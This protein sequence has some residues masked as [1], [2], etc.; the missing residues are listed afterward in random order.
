MIFF[1]QTI[2]CASAVITL[3]VPGGH[4]AGPFFMALAGLFY[5]QQALQRTPLTD[6][7]IQASWIWLLAGF[8]SL[9]IIGIG[10]SLWHPTH[11]GHYEMYVP[12]VLFPAMAWLIRADRCRV[13]PWLICLSAGALLAFFYAS[14]QVFELNIARAYGATNHPIPFGNT[15]IVLSAVALVAGAIFPFEGPHAQW[16]RF[17]V[18]IAGAAG[19]GASLLSGSRGGWLS[20]FIVGFTVAYLATRHWPAWR[21]HLCAA[22]VIASLLLAGFLAPSHL[23]KDRLVTGF[24]GG[25]QWL[26]TG[27]VSDGSVGMRMEIWRLSFK[28][29]AEK[30]WFG[31]GSIGA[32]TRWEELRKEPTASP[33]LSQLYEPDTK[34]V[35][36]DNE[37]LGTL[38]G[39][40]IVGVLAVL[41]AYLGNWIA[42][43]RWRSHSDLQIKTL[44]TIGLLLPPIY[45]EF[46]L[47]VSVFGTN[48]FRSVFVMLSVSLLALLSVRFYALKEAS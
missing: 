16:K 13:E 46:G 25:M 10:L 36:F 29:I 48:V 34:F 14:Y 47:T 44:A 39:G 31:H 45:L 18:Y 35:S 8:W 17:F 19:V 9:V 11:A 26:Q 20:L 2:F 4:F 3:V 28:V 38:A 5:R 41:S 27:E 33:M 32:H 15:A 37:W 23:V 6:P 42:F 30:P 1:W 7:V 22:A 40:G 12:F 24:K 21:R 43:W